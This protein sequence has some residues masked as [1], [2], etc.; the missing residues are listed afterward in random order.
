M[1]QQFVETI[2]IKNGQAQNLV[3]HQ[4]RMEMTIRHFFPA[5]CLAPMPSLEKLVVANADM[6]FYKARVVYGANGVETVE[7]AP[8]TMKEIHSL[9]VVEDNT[10]D[11]SFKS[12]DRS[13]L[14][15]LAAKKG[16][17]D[18]I[19]IVKQGLLRD[20]SFTNLAIYVGRQWLTPKHP[21]LHGTKRASLLERGFIHEADITLDDLRKAQKVSLFN[22]MIEFGEREIPIENIHMP[23]A[24]SKK[25]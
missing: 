17:C 9:Q 6:D 21:L 13:R 12:T 14:N 7:Y 24:D 19:I 22:A 3:R 25:D 2:K 11:Y 23:N 5:L 1:N 16:D 8:Y 20:T 15:A 4:E 10:I 18:E